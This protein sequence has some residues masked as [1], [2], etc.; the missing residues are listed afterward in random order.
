MFKRG[1]LF[2]VIV[3]CP[4]CKDLVHSEHLCFLRKLE[5]KRTTE[6]LILFYFEADQ[7]TDEHKINFAVAEYLDRTEHT[8]KGILHLIND[9]YSVSLSV[10]VAVALKS[11]FF[12][13]KRPNL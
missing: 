2:V 12:F 1:S 8:D 10:P 7:S 9:L 11:V 13:F 6:K 3:I 4:S 5:P